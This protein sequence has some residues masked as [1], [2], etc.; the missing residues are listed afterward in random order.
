MGFKG[1]KDPYAGPAGDLGAL[2][3]RRQREG[4]A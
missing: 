3:L 4:E 2:R 1:S